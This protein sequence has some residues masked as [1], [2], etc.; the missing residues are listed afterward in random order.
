MRAARSTSKPVTCEGSVFFGETSGPP[1]SLVAAPEGLAG[2]AN[3]CEGVGGR[4]EG[5][6]DR[7]KE[8]GDGSLQR[9]ILASADGSWLRGGCLRG[10]RAGA[11]LKSNARGSQG[12]A[13]TNG[14]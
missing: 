3:V 13:L 8:E 4:G 1:P 5:D 9:G 12:A 7:E 10:A 6:E 14:V 11:D 2:L